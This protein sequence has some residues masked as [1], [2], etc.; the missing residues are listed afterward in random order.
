MLLS[1]KIVIVASAALITL[2]GAFTIQQQIGI[3]HQDTRFEDATINAKLALWRNIVRV[4]INGLKSSLKSITRNRGAL[5]ALA[6]KDATEL[7]DE[8]IGTY[9]RLST[10]NILSEVVIV[11]PDG[12]TLFPADATDRT[13]GQS[14]LVKK[15]LAEKT[16]AEGVIKRN[17]GP[18]IAI[19]TPL[20]KGRDV[21]GVALVTKTLK[22]PAQDFKKS[23][24]SEVVVLRPDGTQ[25]SSTEKDLQVAG[26]AHLGEQAAYFLAAQPDGRVFRSVA[27]PLRDSDGS[28]NGY[29]VAATDA[30][31]FVTAER[32]FNLISY[33]SIGGVMIAFL[34]LITLFLKRSF[35]PLNEVTATI[36]SLADGNRDIEIDETARRDEI[37]A[38]WGAVGIFKDNMIE[39]E[40][41]ASEQ[42]K[43]EEQARE[44]EQQREQE[45][46]A[47]EQAALEEKEKADAQ[48]AQDRRDAML[49]FADKFEARIKKIVDNVTDEAQG[50]KSASQDMAQMMQATATKTEF[51]ANT[52]SE[53]SG[54]VQ[55]IASASEELTASIGEISRQ[56]GE[57]KTI[58]EAAAQK[59]NSVSDR[60]G[61]LETA[62]E[63]I[64]EVITLI[65]DIASQTN[66]LAL[67]A[68]IEAARAGEAGKGFAVVATE[69]KSLADQ[70]AKAT[71]EISI[72]ILAIQTSTGDAVTGIGEIRDT[73][74]QVE[75]L[76]TSISGAIEQQA[77]ATQEI[78]ETVNQAATGTQKVFTQLSE[79]QE[80]VNKSETT[81]REFVASAERLT[82]SGEALRDGVE[83]FLAEV[84][85]G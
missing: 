77:Q 14:T 46:L 83:E 16:R 9:N 13:A 15:T 55:G 65:N 22:L 58:S 8:L 85:A 68:T 34:L 72:Q 41:L 45:R 35:R 53:A 70:T 12:K 61:G 67:N 5:S 59:A 28:L 81:A 82:E 27:I 47:A 71:E 4:E 2:G 69:V 10:A 42:Q 38:I 39:A 48:A 11:T 37:G 66:L 50:T 52:S 36:Q 3:Q 51:V 64:G 1:K 54:N 24:N 44:Q 7:N 80:T 49:A 29:L 40:R 78:S 43:A 56:A 25:I 75:A 20:Y 63:K 84:R 76:S 23:D 74:D 57:S 21:I 6:K 19:S 30:T 31:A 62:A 26:T 33:G 79:V 73:I 60:I 17:G 18:A 32:K